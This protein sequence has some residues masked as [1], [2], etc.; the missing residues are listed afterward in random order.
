[1]ISSVVRSSVLA[2]PYSTV[3]HKPKSLTDI[4]RRAIQREDEE[5]VKSCIEEGVPINRR[6]VNAND[7]NND[8]HIVRASYIQNRNIVKMLLQAKADPDVTCEH[9]H[10]PLMILSERGNKEL[11]KV[12]L[13]AGANVHR[14]DNEG[15]NALLTACRRTNNFEEFIDLLL[16]AG[17][18]IHHTCNQGNSALMHLLEN[19]TVGSYFAWDKKN[20]EIF[21]AV[22]RVINLCDVNLANN[23]GLTPLM[24]TLSKGYFGFVE[25]LLQ[26]G[27][28]PLATNKQGQNSIEIAVVKE[29]KCKAKLQN[30][31]EITQMISEAAKKECVKE[32]DMSDDKVDTP[33]IDAIYAEKTR[34]VDE[35]LSQGID[36]NQANECGRKP[37]DYAIS[38]GNPK[39]VKSLLKANAHV[40]VKDRFGDHSLKISEHYLQQATDTAKE[41]TNALNRL[42][43]YD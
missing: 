30:Y 33:L 34:K 11:V 37:M 28:D 23:K 26:K 21:N 16:A 27:A 17:A 10:T 19:F 5:Q 20:I 38:K 31:E 42:K 6:D 13:K 14:V 18:D 4:M 35:L 8:Y 41:A 40:L 24:V 9:G 12:L 32:G 2:R 15:L 36:P 25:P 3:A 1:M 22:E 39:I 7:G 29:Q 43:R